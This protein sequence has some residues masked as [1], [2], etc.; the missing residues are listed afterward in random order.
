[1][2]KKANGSP[3]AAAPRAK[4]GAYRPH[5][6]VQKRFV[7]PTRAKQ[8][9]ADE[10]NI[11]NIMARYEKTGILEHVRQHPGGYGDVSGAVPYHEAIDIVD[12]AQRS[13]MTLPSKIR[14][15]FGNDPGEFLEWVTNPANQAEII[16][17]GLAVDGRPEP[18][19]AEQPSAPAQGAPAPAEGADPAP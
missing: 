5:A 4:Y 6:R 7:L 9:M 19:P 17:L 3:P 2:T 12:R 10:C 14:R 16:E 1:M 15:R 18:P 11:N 8:A 13:F